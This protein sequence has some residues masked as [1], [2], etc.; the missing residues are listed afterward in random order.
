MTKNDNDTNRPPSVCE[1]RE[2]ATAQK[3][4]TAC[5]AI[6]HQNQTKRKLKNGTSSRRCGGKT[7]EHMRR[8]NSDLRRWQWRR[9]SPEYS[10]MV[11]ISSNSKCFG[12]AASFVR[13]SVAAISFCL[14]YLMRRPGHRALHT[15]HNTH[16]CNRMADR[17]D[18]MTQSH[19]IA[20]INERNISWISLLFLSRQI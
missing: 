6:I 1:E 7:C 15:E 4:M 5:I 3:E 20:G 19:A 8:S 14:L 16:H 18:E 12:S 13:C 9:K 2:T 17:H 11:S 10:T